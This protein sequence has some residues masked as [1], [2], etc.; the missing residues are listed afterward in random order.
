MLGRC[1]VAEVH[2]AHAIREHGFVGR[3]LR[4]RLYF[5]LLSLDDVARVRERDN[6]RGPRMLGRR[7]HFFQRLDALPGP[8]IIAQLQEAVLTPI[9]GVGHVTG[10]I[11][12]LP[13]LLRDVEG[14][15]VLMRDLV[16][17]AV[18]DEDVRRHVDG[19]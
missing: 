5:P 14:A 2:G 7:L 9:P 16:P 12:R 13:Q 6:A 3:A 15:H 19:V 4:H 18:L 11:S 8:R 10:D 1:D 17:H